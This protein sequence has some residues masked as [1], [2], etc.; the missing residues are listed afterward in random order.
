MQPHH[1]RVRFAFL[2]LVLVAC[3]PVQKAAANDPQ[4]C[5]RDP[6]CASKNSRAKDCSMQCVDNIDCMRTCEEIQGH[7]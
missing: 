2:L 4:R 3:G 7:R 5:E 1:A 6:N